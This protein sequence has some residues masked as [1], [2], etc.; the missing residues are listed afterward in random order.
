[1][2]LATL[3]S[4]AKA[5]ASIVDQHTVSEQFQTHFKEEM[6]TRGGCPSDWVWLNPSQSGSLTPLYHQEM[7]HYTLSPA[8]DRQELP[9]THYRFP[10]DGEKRIFKLK[11]VFVAIRFAVALYRMKR[12]A[13]QTV[14]VFYAT[15]TGTAKKFATR[16][17]NQLSDLFN[18]KLIAMNLFD[19]M[20]GREFDITGYCLFVTSTFGNGDPPRM[21]E[22]LASWLDK[23]L[24]KIDIL[25]TKAISIP[26]TVPELDDQPVLRRKGGTM[27]KSK[28]GSTLNQRMSLRIKTLKDFK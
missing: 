14:K 2:N 13:R 4:F 18:V 15:E 17:A 3:Y 7:L 19:E 28:R 12:A 11:S 16:L 8:L 24:T 25:K 26:D 27:R 23:R 20:E 1:M 21:A 6:K 10:E 22:K 9:W 5:G